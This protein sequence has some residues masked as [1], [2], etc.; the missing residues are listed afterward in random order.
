MQ[1]RV[2]KHR[3]SAVDF[4]F[5]RQRVM[6]PAVK[7][8][9]FETMPLYKYQACP[10][11][12]HE[13]SERVRQIFVEHQLFFASRTSFNDPFDCR[14]P[15]FLETPGTILKR[16]VEEFV[17]RKFPNSTE[18]EKVGAMSGLMSVGA[19]EG[20]RKGLQE[21]V[22]G[23]GIVCFSKV[24]NDILMWAHYA[25]KHKGLSLEFEGV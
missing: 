6:M 24:R 8:V 22:D 10:G 17:D 2:C 20:L 3:Y 16:F 19:L 9:G 5:G 12:D 13:R 15:S 4:K 11:D 7:E 23:A 25:D 21:E 1:N 14:V 18:T